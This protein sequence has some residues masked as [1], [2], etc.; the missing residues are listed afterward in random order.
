M[1]NL[2]WRTIMI[3]RELKIENKLGIHARP[4]TLLVQKSSEFISS[5][6]LIKDGA[7]ADVKSIMSIMML[8]AG[9]GSVVTLKVEGS[10]EEAAANAIEELIK[11][12]FGEE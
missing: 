9:Y 4:S 10:D 2:A 3:E 7:D 11:G 8:A 6:H 1:L 5:I 12:K